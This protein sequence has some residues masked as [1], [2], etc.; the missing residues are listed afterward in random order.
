[1]RDRCTVSVLAICFFSATEWWLTEIFTTKKEQR[2]PS[3][4]VTTGNHGIKQHKQTLS[5]ADA[6]Q[7]ID[8]SSTQVTWKIKTGAKIIFFE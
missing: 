5:L 4:P 8:R 3:S 1:M 6:E 2:R 7:S